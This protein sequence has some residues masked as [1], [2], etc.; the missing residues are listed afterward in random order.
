MTD[1]RAFFVGAL[2]TT[3]EDGGPQNRS[4]LVGPTNTSVYLAATYNPLG[5]WRGPFTLNITG[6]DPANPKIA[7]PGLSA[8][9]VE[10][11]SC[12]TDFLSYGLNADAL[13]YGPSPSSHVGCAYLDCLLKIQE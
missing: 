3:N 8:C 9:T 10:T 5:R 1:S 2:H 13:W 4:L 12:Y 6:L 11:Y 7:F